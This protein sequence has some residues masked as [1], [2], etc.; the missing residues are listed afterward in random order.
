MKVL[1]I[2]AGSTSVKYNLYQMDTEAV[3][4]RGVVERVGT[5]GAVHSFRAGAHTKV[6]EE[7]SAP[8]HRAAIDVILARHSREGGVLERREDIRA[9]GHRVVHGGEKLVR[10]VLVTDEV[11]RT[12][13]ECALFAPIHNPANLSGIEAAQQALPDVPHVAVFDTAFHADLPPASFVYGVPYELYLSQSIRRYGF[14]GPSH[15]FMAASAAEYLQTSPSRLKLVTCHLG[16]G[17]SVSAIDGGRSV[18]TSMGMTPLEGLLMA[19]RSGDV[20]PAL[21]LLLARQGMSPAAVD[22]ML[23]KKSGLLGLSGVSADFRDVERAANEGNDRARLAIEVFVHK[24]KKYVGAYAAVLGGADAIVFTGGIGENSARVRRMVCEGLLYMGVAVDDAKNDGARPRDTGAGVIDVSQHRAPTKVLVVATD[25]ERMIAREVLRTIAGPTAARTRVTGGT[26][27]VGVSVRHV[28]LSREHCDALFGAGYELSMK[29][30]VSQPGQF[31]CRET[32]DLVGTKGE[33]TRVAIINPLRKE[34]QVEVAKT[35]AYTLGIDA[36]LRES[37]KLDGTPGLTL[38][39]PNGTVQLPKGVIMAHRHVHMNPA[40]ASQF[41]VKDGAVIRVRVEGDRETVFGDVI[42]RV[43]EDFA[44]DM[45]VDTDEANAAAL[46][47]DSV[48]AFDGPQ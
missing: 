7:I 19:T 8:D 44:L 11:K 13:A 2:N 45:H 46:H 1:V 9:V 5:P 10:P 40:E 37:G 20:D 38:R 25:E 4:A 42:V 39:G 36:P 3:L 15:Q 29:R 34:T 32:V 28:H 18:D 48:V 47:N 24:I 12:I 6:E 41:G 16:G 33:I 21:G 17:A 30:P 22:E 23:N 31:V 35:D 27:P 26:I 43:R 14:H